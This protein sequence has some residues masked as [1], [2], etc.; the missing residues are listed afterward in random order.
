ME[1]AVVS[2]SNA[3]WA[4]TLAERGVNVSARADLRSF[5]KL[6]S[7]PFLVLKA[8]GES[9]I[10]EIHGAGQLPSGNMRLCRLVDKFTGAVHSE[11]INELLAH[12][13]GDFYPKT[14]L[15]T[16][17]GPK[18]YGSRVDEHPMLE[19][20]MSDILSVWRSVLSTFE[21]INADQRPYYRY[22]RPDSGFTNC[23]IVLREAMAQANFPAPVPA[24]T[25]AQTGWTEPAK[26]AIKLAV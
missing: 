5:G 9:I 3:A 8:P 12:Y 23:Q 26:P 25:L 19:G 4:I 21:T 15:F 13:S 24:L 2:K 16:R 17:S 6:F 7:H 14:R 18:Q 10:S 1:R 11:R 20:N 22:A